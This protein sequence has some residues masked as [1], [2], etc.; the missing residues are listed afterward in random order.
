LKSFRV[1]FLFLFGRLAGSALQVLARTPLALRACCGLSAAIRGA[2]GALQVGIV[3]TPVAIF[4]FPQML[5]PH[6]AA[7]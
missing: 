5:S 4:V 7:F 6:R 3:F 1:I 2:G